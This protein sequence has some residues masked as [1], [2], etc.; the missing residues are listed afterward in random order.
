MNDEET[1]LIIDGTVIESISIEQ[2]EHLAE[3]GCHVDDGVQNILA[4]ADNWQ[5]PKEGNSGS[6]TATA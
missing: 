1:P 4:A 2:L 3:N 5:P 6:D